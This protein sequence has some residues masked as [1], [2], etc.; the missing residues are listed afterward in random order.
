MSMLDVITVLIVSANPVS[1]IPQASRLLD[2]LGEALRYKH[3]ILRS[4]E[5]YLYWVNFFVGWHC[6]NGQARHP[7]ALGAAEVE[8]FLT[9]LYTAQRVFVHPQSGKQAIGAL[10]FLY[11]EV[12]GGVMAG[13]ELLL[14]KLLCGSG[15]RAQRRAA[16]A[17]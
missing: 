12:P 13:V 10:L 1:Y 15:A 5:A 11:R 9:M 16:P 2:Q 8:Q 3:Y 6:C 14:A 4:E 17:I 7:R